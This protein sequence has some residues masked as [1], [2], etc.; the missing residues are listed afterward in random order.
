M[1]KILT[2]A[3]TEIVVCR[4]IK[5]HLSIGLFIILLGAGCSQSQIPTFNETRAFH[6]L[7]IQ[8]QFGPRYPS[9]VGHQQC[10]DF[11]VDELKKTADRVVKQ[12]FFHKDSRA[13]KTFTMTNI[14]ASFGD[15]GDRLLLCAHW[16]TRPWADHDPDPENQDK[17]IIGANDGASGV[18]VLLEMAQIFKASPPTIGVDIVF[19]DGEDSGNSDSVESWC[20][21]SRYFAQNKQANYLPRYGILLDMI[22]DRDL[23]LPIEIN[24]Q[25]Y[26][27][28]IINLVWSK[29]E[30]LNLHVFDRSLG[31][32]MI[33]DHLELLRVGIPAID[34]IDFDYPHWHTLQD[35]EDKCSPES[36]GIIGTLL[37][38]LIY[39]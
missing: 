37:V 23:H 39:E 34:I 31:H 18:A 26:A 9:S 13:N 10:L 5:I 36:L 21:G 1:F 6:F 12:P 2:L 38:H 4:F 24:S 27:P 30:E 32:Q 7:E 33:D 14:I 28:E 11:L 15:Q 3:F 29:A 16:D 20:L 8:C 19:F 17:P 22:G 35:T 25:R